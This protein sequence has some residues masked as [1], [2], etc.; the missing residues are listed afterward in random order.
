[1]TPRSSFALSLALALAFAG[2]LPAHADD[3][4]KPGSVRAVR[5]TVESALRVTGTIEVDAAGNVVAWSLDQPEK[6]PPEVARMAEANVPKWL[7]EPVTLPEGTPAS[8]M[9]MSMLFVAREMPDGSHRLALRHPSFMPLVAPQFT[10]A[11]HG[12]R[13]YP[14]LAGKHN[15]TGMV[16][17][18]LRIHRSGKVT[19]AMVEQVNLHV[20]DRERNMELWRKM[21]GDAAL[22]DALKTQ[23]NVPDGAFPPGVDERVTRMMF[24]FQTEASPAPRYGEWAAYVPGPRAEISWREA[25]DLTAMAPDALP[26]DVMQVSNSG[27]RRLRTT[28]AP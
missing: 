9:R 13:T 11:K 3:A 20:V 14:A 8:R 6:L 5:A 16:F 28:R 18:A 17:I 10:V 7:F 15:V 26:P 25:S 12:G 27:I 21:L 22:R 24:V 23:F 19:D 4:P 2:P 1:M